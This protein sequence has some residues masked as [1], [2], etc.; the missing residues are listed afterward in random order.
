MGHQSY[1]LFCKKITRI[2]PSEGELGISSKVK[3]FQNSSCYILENINENY[4]KKLFWL[5]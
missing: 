5:F 2:L 1:E 4:D 3:I